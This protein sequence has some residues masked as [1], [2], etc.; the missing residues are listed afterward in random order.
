MS[1]LG[2]ALGREV[3]QGLLS[4]LG[5]ENLEI[6]EDQEA[7]EAVLLETSKYW[8]YASAQEI[9]GKEEPCVRRERCE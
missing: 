8:D 4:D 3:A 7:V 9:M 1:I 2:N 5:Y 6:I